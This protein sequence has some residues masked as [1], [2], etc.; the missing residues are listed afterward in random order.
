MIDRIRLHLA[1]ALSTTAAA[2]GTFVNSEDQKRLASYQGNAQTYYE[3]RRYDQAEDQVRKG[4]EIDAKDYKL[5]VILGWIHLQ[6]A[7]ANPSW[8]RESALTQD[9]VIGNMEYV[10][11]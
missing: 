7:Q 3:G 11:R 4:L 2:C 5:N 6:R 9:V 10:L 8:L 1:L